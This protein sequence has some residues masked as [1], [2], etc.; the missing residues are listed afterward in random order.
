MRMK[1]LV[2]AWYAFLLDVSLYESLLAPFSITNSHPSRN[3][4]VLSSIQRILLV[5]T[6]FHMEISHL[7][8]STDH[9]TGF[10][11]VHL[12]V[13]GIFKEFIRII[14]PKNLCVSICNSF[15]TLQFMHILPKNVSGTL[16]KN[17]NLGYFAF[18]YFLFGFFLILL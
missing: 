9:L 18:F 13:R 3:V 10:Y 11:M 15:N 4:I 17:F 14:L 8:S 12:I 16:L 6:H 1:W 5:E 7:V 2:S